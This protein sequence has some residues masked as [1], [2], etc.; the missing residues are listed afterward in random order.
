MILYLFSLFVLGAIIGSFL[1]VV[2][3]RFGTGTSFVSGRSKCFSCGH[4][5]S[6]H[7]L[8]PIVSFLLL[9]G[10][11]KYCGSKI[12][13]QYFFVE[14]LTAVLFLASGIFIGVPASTLPGIL[15]FLSLIIICFYIVIAVY[16]MHHKIIPD[17]LSYSVA[18]VALV[19]TTII[20]FSGAHD[21]GRFLAG[22]YCALPFFL[23]WLV[24][25]GEW[26]GLGDAK[27]ALS[28]G[29]WLG[30]SAGFASL[31]L[32]VWS[33][34]IIGIFIL[35]AERLKTKSF[36][37]GRHEM[38]FGPFI[39]LGAIAAYLFGITLATILGAL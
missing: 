19:Y 21:Y 11:C 13:K 28:V 32:A 26:M 38:P 39:I 8:F 9:G 17:V 25:R 30:I 14:F 23:L 3:L 18:G 22:I 10:K 29:W 35:I 5:L 4:G 36:R 1:N 27:L 34:A 2:I 15:F 12:S 20:I 16:D 37:F 6:W 24:S 7:D 31:C 33:G